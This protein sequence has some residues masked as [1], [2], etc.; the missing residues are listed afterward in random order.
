MRILCESHYAVAIECRFNK[1][2]FE[3]SHGV[4]LLFHETIFHYFYEAFYTF[5]S[6]M[7]FD[8]DLAQKLWYWLPATKPLAPISTVFTIM[9]YPSF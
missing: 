2:H 4:F 6:I 3:L 5:G 7:P 9:L 1:L 8:S